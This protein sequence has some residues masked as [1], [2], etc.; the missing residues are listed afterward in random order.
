MDKDSSKPDFPKRMGINPGKP[1]LKTRSAHFRLDGIDYKIGKKNPYY[2]MV[3]WYEFLEFDILVL[4]STTMDSP[5][6]EGVEG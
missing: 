4:V 5:S 2:K 3:R 6:Y 1:L